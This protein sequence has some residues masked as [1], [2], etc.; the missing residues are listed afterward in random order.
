M[1]YFFILCNTIKYSKITIYHHLNPFVLF[2][3]QAFSQHMHPS[4]FSQDFFFFLAFSFFHS[5][6]FLAPCYC[7]SL[8]LNPFNHDQITKMAF[9]VSSRCIL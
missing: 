3:K 9:A 7:M 5:I 4:I 6:F 1:L 2:I 8:N